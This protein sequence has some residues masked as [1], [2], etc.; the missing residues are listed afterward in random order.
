MS[1]VIGNY[2]P[3]LPFLKDAAIDQLN[4]EFAYNETGEVDDLEYL[5]DHLRVGMGVIDVCREH[6]DNPDEIQQRV[7]T[8]IDLIGVDRIALNPDC[9][10]A[11]DAF[12]PTTIDEAFD[13]LIRLT[14][15]AQKLR[16]QYTRSE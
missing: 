11:P 16:E 2:K 10:F 4:L 14:D 12:E 7:F 5:P 8:G 15:T 6:V 3:L 9:G 1:D 13:K